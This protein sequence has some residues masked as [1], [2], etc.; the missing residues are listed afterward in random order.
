MEIL[1]RSRRRNFCFAVLV[2]FLLAPILNARVTQLIITSVESP[3]FG[4]A[5]FGAVGQY[6]L[7]QGTISGEVDPTNPQNAVIVDIGLAPRNARGMVSYSADFQIIRPI[8]LAA[9]NHRVLFD[10]PNRG[11]ATLLNTVNG[12]SGN[13]KTGSGTPG[14]G[15]LMNQGYTIVEASW[16]IAAAPSGFTVR[17][18][19]ATNPDGSTLT[20]IALEEFVIDKNATPATQPLTYA[21][22]TADKSQATLTVREN[23]GD[24]P[25]VIPASGWD[26]TDA[27]LTAVKL[28][29]GPFGGP[30]SFGP[31]AL[32]EFTYMARDPIVSGLGFAALRDLGTFLRNAQTDDVGTANPLAGDV[33]KMI[34]TCVSQPCRTMHDF[35]LFGFNRAEL[36]RTAGRSGDEGDHEGRS[37]KVFD[38]VINWIGGGDGIFM[39]YRFAQPGRTQRQ[40]IARWYPEFQF[41]WAN[42]RIHDHVTDRTAGRLDAC[43]RTD[44]CPKI[45]EMNSENEFYSK[46]GSMLTTDTR[47]RDLDLDET[48]NVR[49]YLMSSLPHG[50]GTAAGICQQPQNPLTPGPVLRALT[51]DVD[52]WITHGSPPPANRVPRRMDGTL[53]PSLPQ[54]SVGF[55]EIPGVNY[56]GLMHTGDLFNYG[57]LFSRGIINILPPIV[58][59]TPY[60]VFVPRTDSDGNDVAGIRL[61]DISVPLA[62]YTGYARRASAPGDPVPIEDGC[63]ASGQRIPF[64]KT[65]AARLAAGDPRPSLAERYPDHATYVN[66]VTQAAKQLQADRLLLDFDVE[67]YIAAAQAASVP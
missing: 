7:I 38:A 37:Q 23:F 25:T 65:K 11:R 2:V 52:E 34:T 4:G 58:I 32:Y 66:M 19:I 6:E 36:S 59:G 51:L 31:T 29:S 55:P 24:A 54:S 12:G 49:Y 45:I 20:G 43:Q 39:N 21:A 41:P 47:G 56:N 17:L 57:P 22:A 33:Q 46:G 64:A 8:N 60:P 67:A 15:F 35:V 1:S 3:T 5:S 61:P 40:H 9:G 50:A 30:G 16:D 14:N 48:P 28:T 63:D 10:L 44:T 27:S 53:V 62:T 13:S 26:F 18:P 42:Q